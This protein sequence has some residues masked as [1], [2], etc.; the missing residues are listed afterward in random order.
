MTR[1]SSFAVAIAQSFEPLICS[2]LSRLHS[3]SQWVDDAS[4]KCFTHE[5]KVSMAVSTGSVERLFLNDVKPG[6]R[7]V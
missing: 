6:V 3:Q 1:R 7:G 5:M 2:R 4:M